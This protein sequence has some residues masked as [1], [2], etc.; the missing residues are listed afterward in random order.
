MRPTAV[1]FYYIPR[2]TPREGLETLRVIA[3][4]AACLNKVGA[5]ERLPALYSRRAADNDGSDVKPTL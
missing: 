5:R 3:A 2:S 1:S 4:R